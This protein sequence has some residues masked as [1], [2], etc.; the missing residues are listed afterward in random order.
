MSEA[1]LS[2]D[3]ILDSLRQK[4]IT[5]VLDLVEMIKEDFGV[6]DMPV[7]AA[8]VAPAGGEA[9]AAQEEKTEFNVKLKSFGDKKINVIKVIRAVTGLALKEAKD[10]VESAP[11]VVKENTSK[12][13][14]ED[15]KKQLEEAGAEVEIE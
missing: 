10:L 1:V 15:L 2:N 11:A 14:A 12:E 9:E 3:Q 5:E 4:S 13:D 6:S 8:G 7:F